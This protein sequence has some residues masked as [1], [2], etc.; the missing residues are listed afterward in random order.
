MTLEQQLNNQ[1]A[2][3]A[4]IL[5]H[6]AHTPLG[7]AIVAHLDFEL[8]WDL[9]RRYVPRLACSNEDQQ[10]GWDAYLDAEAE[11]MTPKTSWNDNVWKEYV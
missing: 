10:R 9:C 6:N 7:A 1:I 3:N 4:S 11:A 2:R 8:G 5:A